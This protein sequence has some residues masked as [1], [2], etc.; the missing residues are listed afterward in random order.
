MSSAPV[1]TSA[2][3]LSALLLGCD[4]V[5]IYPLN[6]YVPSDAGDAASG[7]ADAGRD[8]GASRDGGAE[9]DLPPLDAGP[10]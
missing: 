9:P 7:A 2:F 6:E 1:L 5:V 4:D 8:A 10:R 3:L